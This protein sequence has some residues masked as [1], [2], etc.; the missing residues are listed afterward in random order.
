MRR[1]KEDTYNYLCTLLVWLALTAGLVALVPQ[2]V[3]A[4]GTAAATTIANT[5]FVSFTLGSNPTPLT[6][7]ASDSF[8]VLEI[9]DVALAW[10]DAG[11]LPVDSPHTDA[12]LTFLVTNTGN[13]PEDIRLLPNTTVSGDDFNPVAPFL[14]IETNSIA[15]LQADD[16]PYAAPVLLNAD[17]AVV[18][19]LL[20]DIPGGRS[21]G[22]AGQVQLVAEA[23]TPGAAGQSAGTMLANAGMNNVHAV[24]G[25]TNADGL[26]SGIYRVST[27]AVRLT[28]SIQGIAD[29]HGGNRP[30]HNAT[31]RYRIQV[32]VEGDGTAQSLSI[33]DAV[34]PEMT[35][36]SGSILLDGVARTDAP[37]GD[38]A[39][40]NTAASIVTVNLG[41][42]AAPAAFIIE[43][44]AT[45]NH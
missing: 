29:T 22:E 4:A 35:Y 44:D 20:C 7:T 36:V 27:L 32:D 43:F 8:E 24:V 18:V 23:L 34:P 19:Y 5:A 2:P 37:D 16:T 10:Q 26:A 42:I 1:L 30:E 25:L 45:I 41:D 40:F 31:I 38:N 9:I 11:E 6:V 3:H 15:G 39:E 13:G 12:L 21:Q 28:K 14:W 17:Q 33:T